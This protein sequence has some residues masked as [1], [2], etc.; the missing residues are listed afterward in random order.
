MHREDHK[1]ELKVRN[2]RDNKPPEEVKRNAEV[3]MA[4]YDAQ[5]VWMQDLMRQWGNK[6]L[7]LASRAMSAKR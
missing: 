2:I 5:P 3:N 6:P 1:Q 7:S 4:G